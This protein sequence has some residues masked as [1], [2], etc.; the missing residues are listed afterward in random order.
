MKKFKKLENVSRARDWQISI[1]A[2]SDR[3]PP[4]IDLQDLFVSSSK[5][6]HVMG[7][8][9]KTKKIRENALHRKGGYRVAKQW[10]PS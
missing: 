9:R 3:Y 4:Y 7:Y 5:L 6:S 8:E 2:Y 1:L 10:P